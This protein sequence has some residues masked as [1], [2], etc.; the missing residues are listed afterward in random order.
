MN[1]ELQN[2]GDTTM[3]SSPGWCLINSNIFL[4]EFLTLGQQIIHVKAILSLGENYLLFFWLFH[5]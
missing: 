2:D 3:V 1:Y 4:I 5:I